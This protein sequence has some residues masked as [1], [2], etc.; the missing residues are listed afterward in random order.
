MGSNVF[1]KRLQLYSINFDLTQLY[2]TVKTKALDSK[3]IYT[4]KN[5]LHALLCIS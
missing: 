2:T 3:P 4:F 1:K 5:N